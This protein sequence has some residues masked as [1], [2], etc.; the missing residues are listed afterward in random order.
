MNLSSVFQK[1][2]LYGNRKLLTGSVDG[3]R[4]WR[5]WNIVVPLNVL[6]P[7]LLR[8]RSLIIA[9]HHHC[10]PHRVRVTIV[11]LLS[12]KWKPSCQGCNN[13]QNGN[14]LFWLPLLRFPLEEP[15]E[16]PLDPH[17]RP[18]LYLHPGQH[19]H[20]KIYLLNHSSHPN[21]WSLGQHFHFF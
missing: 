12:S 11:I 10:L 6:L 1:K 7:S 15:L 16:A 8:V 4:W 13:H 21:I 5:R 18:H 17:H 2:L 14:L 19:S 9:D 20:W 3:R